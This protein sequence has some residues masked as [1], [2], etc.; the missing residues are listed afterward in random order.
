MKPY[1]TNKSSGLRDALRLASVLLGILQ[2]CAFTDTHVSL[3]YEPVVPMASTGGAAVIVEPFVDRRP[4]PTVVGEVRNLNMKRT[5][6]KIVDESVGAWVTEAF[7]QE[8][9]RAGLRPAGPDS[10]AEGSITGSVEKF[11]ISSNPNFELICDL[12][13]RVIARRGSATV[14]DQVYVGKGNA[15]AEWGLQSEDAEAVR[16]ALQAITRVAVPEIVRAIQ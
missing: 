5:A 3:S 14:L 10:N 7:S 16:E 13:V 9:A 1:H 8:L 15:I 6:D 11:F 12:R 4:N 2:G